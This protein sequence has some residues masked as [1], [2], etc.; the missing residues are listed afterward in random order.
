MLCNILSRFVIHWGVGKKILNAISHIPISHRAAS[1]VYTEDWRV[2]KHCHRG[3]QGWHLIFDH[4]LRVL[5]QISVKAPHSAHR[6]SNQP[7]AEVCVLI[8]IIHQFCYVRENSDKHVHHS[9]VIG[10]YI[11]IKRHFDVGGNYICLMS[12]LSRQHTR[13]RRRAAQYKQT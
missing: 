12:C 4:Q 5:A 13:S 10:I 9:N 6:R 3:Q 11:Q 2:E 7:L 8:V 1:C